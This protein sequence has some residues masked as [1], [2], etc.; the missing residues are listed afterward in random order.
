[1]KVSAAV[2]GIDGVAGLRGVGGGC[3]VGHDA[4]VHDVA[5]APVLVEIA[6]PAAVPDD[7]LPPGDLRREAVVVHP[8]AVSRVEGIEIVEGVAPDQRAGA[9]LHRAPRAPQLDECLVRERA[10]DEV[11]DVVLL[12]QQVLAAC[13]GRGALV[14]RRVLHRGVTIRVDRST[15]HDP[16]A[17]CAQA[18][19]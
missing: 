13:V 4:V 5:R 16:L 1:M 15:D 18:A 8:R 11:V 17:V 6:S 9:A 19:S 3:E 12:D 7:I 14:L 10:V 2:P